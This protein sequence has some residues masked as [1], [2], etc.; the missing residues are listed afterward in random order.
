MHEKAKSF[1]EKTGTSHHDGPLS[2]H[3]GM[4]HE[5]MHKIEDEHFHGKK[6]HRDTEI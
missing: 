5:D 2:E 3:H 1:L 6:H 4:S